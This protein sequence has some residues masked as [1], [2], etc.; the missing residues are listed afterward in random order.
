M[1]KFKNIHE[2]VICGMD[3]SPNGRYLATCSIDKTINL[4][5]LK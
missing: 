5:D 4:I 2:A 1:H 3:F